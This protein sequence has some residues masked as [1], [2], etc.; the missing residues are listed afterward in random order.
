[1]MDRIASAL[2]TQSASEEMPTHADALLLVPGDG[3]FDTLRRVAENGGRFLDIRGHSRCQVAE[4][5][6]QQAVKAC[7]V[8]MTMQRSDAR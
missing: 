1:M 4:A 3:S 7:C 5:E 2:D 8:R 6:T